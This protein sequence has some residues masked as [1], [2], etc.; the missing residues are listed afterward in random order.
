MSNS[1]LIRGA[2]AIGGKSAAK[3]GRKLELQS[4]LF[5]NTDQG[6]PIR[7]IHGRDRVAG[8]HIFPVFGLWS[9]TNK[10]EGGK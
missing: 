7:V 10:S 2:D 3:P 8:V 5:A 4:K 6:V 1:N 9:K